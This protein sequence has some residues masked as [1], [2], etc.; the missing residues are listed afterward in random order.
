MDALFKGGLEL[1]QITEFYGES[2]T[3]KTQLCLQLCIYA[4]LD[5]PFGLGARSLYISTQKAAN[6]ERLSQL[7]RLISSRHRA[8]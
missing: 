6:E 8:E 4:A 7:L 1:G 2:G 3:G 5:P